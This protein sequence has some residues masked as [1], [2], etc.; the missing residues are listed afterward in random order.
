MLIYKLHSWVSQARW[1][2]NVLKIIFKF[3]PRKYITKCKSNL[4]REI[5]ILKFKNTMIK[6]KGD[7]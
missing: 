2:I 4:G 1:N 6:M 7:W 3:K 5:W